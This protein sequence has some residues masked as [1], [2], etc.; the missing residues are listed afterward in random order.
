MAFINTNSY[1]LKSHNILIC[2]I[3]ICKSQNVSPPNFLQIFILTHF[4]LCVIHQPLHHITNLETNAEILANMD[5]LLLI[6]NPYP[7]LDPIHQNFTEPRGEEPTSDPP[8]FRILFMKIYWSQKHSQVC[9][10]HLHNGEIFELE[11]TQFENGLP[12]SIFP[13]E[14]KVS[15]MP[16]NTL[17]YTSYVLIVLKSMALNNETN[18][19]LFYVRFSQTYLNLKA[20][21]IVE[22]SELVFMSCI[23]CGKARR[24]CVLEDD[25]WHEETLI[26]EQIVRKTNKINDLDDIWYK[27]NAKMD[28]LG[29]ERP[30]HI[31]GMETNACFL[32][33]K[34]RLQPDTL[35]ELCVQKYIFDRLNCSFS[36][37][38]DLFTEIMSM[39]NTNYIGTQSNYQPLTFG[40]LFP[41]IRFFV[42]LSTSENFKPVNT[43]IAD[44]L[45]PLPLHIW[46]ASCS[47]FAGLL[48]ILAK[49]SKGKWKSNILSWTFWL[50]SITFEQGDN[51]RSKRN[52][53]TWIF[54]LFWMFFGLLLRNLYNSTLYSF[55]TKFPDPQNIPKTIKELYQDSNGMHVLSTRPVVE[56]LLKDI[57]YSFNDK[58]L[59]TNIV[60]RTNTIFISPI[61]VGK[62]LRNL[63]TDQPISCGVVNPNSL[64]YS[65]T[66]C[67]SRNRYAILYSTYPLSI[68]QL[69]FLRILIALF[70]QKRIL[71]QFDQ[72]AHCDA[73]LLWTIHRNVVFA[74]HIQKSISLFVE[75]G[76]QSYKIRLSKNLIQSQV[77][78]HA[79]RSIELSDMVAKFQGSV[80]LLSDH[81]T[82]LDQIGLLEEKDEEDM[83]DLI[84]FQDF[85]VILILFSNCMFVSSL[86]CLRELYICL[87]QSK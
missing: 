10:L 25:K 77:L 3:L 27:L 4:N 45:S 81:N 20:I 32:H 73:P 61:N 5:G 50:L 85:L 33:H 22:S 46:I 69:K 63:S 64:Y 39:E 43:N 26:F 7:V 44:L 82:L 59:E 78:K 51:I 72:P 67:D 21:M 29:F 38:F 47:C 12:P 13:T 53:K 15:N 49:L 56:R 16:V 1:L 79:N 19:R 58:H 68:F 65:R 8:E 30:N 71:D 37:C 76:L 66:L 42:V 80:I 36:Q 57:T 2:M 34:S 11:D 75:S 40:S 28:N 54:I 86:T 74:N 83:G 48:L 6:H 9:N 62:Y 84:K 23:S 70:G 35:V 55:I 60:R 41:E 31:N 14:V 87:K 17:F 18:E 52:S 24:I